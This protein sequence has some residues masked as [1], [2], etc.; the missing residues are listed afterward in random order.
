M[1]AHDY[2]KVRELEHVLTRARYHCRA[3]DLT[4]DLTLVR[5]FL[6]GLHADGQSSSSMA[7][8]PRT[9]IAPRVPC[10]PALQLIDRAARL[11]PAQSR[12]RWYEDLTAELNELVTAGLSRPGQLPIVLDPQVH[13]AP[14]PW[15]ELDTELAAAPFAAP[16]KA[17]VVGRPGGPAF[18]SSELA[19]LAHLGGIVSTI[20]GTDLGK[21]HE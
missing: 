9:D 18:R 17:L 4:C 8:R 6:A 14:E 21:G 15:F 12:P 20:L 16:D 5:R 10:R 11:L 7:G 2:A 19:R 13:W 1:N 3:L